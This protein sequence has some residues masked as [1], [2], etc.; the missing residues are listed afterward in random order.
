MIDIPPLKITDCGLADYPSGGSLGPRLMPDYEILW[1]ERGECRWEL[2]G[3]SH[4]CPP[5]SVL[6]C[7]PGS[8]DTWFWDPDEMTRHG[9]LHFE[10]RDNATIDLPIRRD[11]DGDDV[12]RPLLRHAVWLATLGTAEGDELASV[13]LRQALTWYAFGHVTRSA[14]PTRGAIHPVLMRALRALRK[15]WGDGPKYQVSISDWADDSGVSRGHLA[16]VCRQELNVSPQELLRYLRLDNSLGFLNRTNIK[17]GEI[18]EMC[19]FQNQFH[20]SRCFKEA[21]GHSPRELRKR[22]RAG[23][24]R[25]LSKVV[26]MRRMTQIV[27]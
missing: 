22:L 21:Y 8:T 17:I 3:E 18:S 24:D 25:P 6:I 1:I 27:G 10:F 23:G 15:R 13:A 4:V 2:A 14:P 12:L 9:Y 5:G 19:G 26:G 11:C 16:R 20:F 7:K